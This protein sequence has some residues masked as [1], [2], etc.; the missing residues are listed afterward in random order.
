MMR[1]EGGWIL[2]DAMIAAAVVAV[3]LGATLQA[4]ASSARRQGDVAL[5]RRALLLAQS[6]LA[7]VGA[8]IPLEIGES[9][10]VAG[11]LLWRVDVAPYQDQG[12]ATPA[13]TLMSVAVSVRPRV[14]GPVLVELDSLRLAGG[15]AS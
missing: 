15:T 9:S 4:V 14:G 5:H 2:V 6:E 11:G 8:D 10:G 7:D 12:G 1:R 3:T 13:G